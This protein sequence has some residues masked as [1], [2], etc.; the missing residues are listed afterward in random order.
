MTDDELPETDAH[1]DLRKN[2]ISSDKF[3]GKTLCVSIAY[4]W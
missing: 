4:D 3:D 2:L 1:H